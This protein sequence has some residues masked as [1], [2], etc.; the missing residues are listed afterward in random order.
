MLGTSHENNYYD[1]YSKFLI[2]GHGSV[3]TSISGLK[4]IKMRK[5]L[6]INQDIWTTYVLEH[7]WIDTT[8]IPVV[9]SVT[10]ILFYSSYF[11]DLWFGLSSK[12]R[13]LAEEEERKRLFK[14]AGEKYQYKPRKHFD[15]FQELISVSSPEMSKKNNNNSLTGRSFF[16]KAYCFCIYSIVR[17]IVRFHVMYLFWFLCATAQFLESKKWELDILYSVHPVT[18]DTSS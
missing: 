14:L 4:N 11:N 16:E 9:Y 15:D 18:A 6:R 5:I 17:F 3:W 8:L 1:E 2:K 12:H 10:L 13:K 7:E